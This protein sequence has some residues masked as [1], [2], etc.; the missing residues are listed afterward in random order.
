RGFT[1]ISERFDAVGLTTFM[2]RYLT[3]MT[4]AILSRGG[5][6]DKY[7][8]DAIMAFW[9][10][11]LDDADH[12]AHACHA[13]LD[14]VERLAALN[15][16]LDAEAKAAGMEPVRIVIGIGINTAECCVGNM[17]SQQR[18][19]YSV[20]GDGVNLAARLEGQT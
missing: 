1:S 20:L 19:D 17:G 4:D 3:P 18:F 6:V 13:A 10:A 15:A 9:N 2:N 11:P 16:E 7:I 12:A 14:M 5:T 8:G